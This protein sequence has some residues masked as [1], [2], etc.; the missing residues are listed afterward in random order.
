M[1]QPLLPAEIRMLVF[2]DMRPGLH[3]LAGLQ[4]VKLLELGD[5]L[6]IPALLARRFIRHLASVNC[7]AIV[8]AGED[9]VQEHRP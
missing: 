9:A 2:L 5:A 6:S 3:S 1:E 7:V 8:R 4:Q